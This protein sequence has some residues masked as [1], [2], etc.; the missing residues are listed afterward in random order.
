MSCILLAAGWIT[1]VPYSHS[2]TVMLYDDVVEHTVILYD[3]VE[4][5]FPVHKASCALH[6]LFHVYQ[7]CRLWITKLCT[8]FVIASFSASLSLRPSTIFSFVLTS[9]FLWL[10]AY[11][12]FIVCVLYCIPD[13]SIVF[14]PSFIC[15]FSSTLK[16]TNW[17]YFCRESVCTV[18]RSHTL[19]WSSG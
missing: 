15:N 1:Q 7:S 4:Y 14:Y 3:D 8:H 2:H 17:L 9:M 16:I 12:P 10:T 18:F 6:G 5:L 13:W 11:N 19:R